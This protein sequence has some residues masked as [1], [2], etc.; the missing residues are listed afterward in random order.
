MAGPDEEAALRTAR[1]AA[2]QEAANYPDAH[3]FAR[4][5]AERMEQARLS[6]VDWV[7]IDL[8]Q[9]D[10]RDLSSR[11]AIATQIQ[12]I[13]LILRNYLP[14]RAASVHTIVVIFGTDN[15]ATREEV[16]LP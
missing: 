9:Y 11:R 5:L 14:G 1:D 15:L 16:K 2:E 7:K 6:H 3:A 12:R 8:P 13:A 4:E 10:A